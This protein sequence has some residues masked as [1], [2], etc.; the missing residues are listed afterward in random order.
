VLESEIIGV[1]PVSSL[2]LHPLEAIAWNDYK[3]Q[4]IL[5]CWL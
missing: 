3:A 1:I 4:Q 5:E 2:G